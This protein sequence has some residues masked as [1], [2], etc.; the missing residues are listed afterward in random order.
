M[1][2]LGCPLDGYPNV[3][4][5]HGE[6]PRHADIA[7]VGMG[8]GWQEEQDGR[9]FVGPSGQLLNA[10]LADAGVDRA[11]VY[12]TNVAQ[13]RPRGVQTNAGGWIPKAK[14]EKLSMQCCRARCLAELA[15]VRPKIVVAVGTMTME[16]ISDGVKGITQVQGSLNRLAPEAEL[17]DTWVIPLFHPAHLLRG[18]DRFYSVVVEGLKKAKRLAEGGLRPTG[19]LRCIDPSSAT[20]A[21]DL[22]WLR[23]EIDS[24]IAA[25]DDIAV[26]VETTRAEPMDATLTV[27]GFCSLRRKTGIAV[28]VR[29]WNP[30]TASFEFNWNEQQWK[31]IDGCIRDL[32]AAK[33]RFWFW[34]YGFDVTV[35]ERHYKIGGTIG[36]GMVLHHLYQ[37]DLLHGLAFAAQTFLDI[38]PW[39]WLFRQAELAGAATHADLLRYNAQDVLYTALLISILS[40]LVAERGNA[41]LIEHQLYM[42]D[43]ARRA[44]LR[45]IPI[46]L[47]AWRKA[48]F[49]YEQRRYATLERIKE[50]IRSSD[51]AA[52]D[53]SKF[54]QDAR[55]WRQKRDVEYELLDVEQFNPAS[56]DHGR[57]LLYRFLKLAP[58][59]FTKGGAEGD[60]KQPS[61]SY[62]GVLNHLDNPLVKAYVDN[63]EVTAVMRALK[64]I[65]EHLHPVTG[66]LHPTWNSVGMAG[67]RWVSKINVQN[68]DS[69]LKS[70]SVQPEGRV[71]IAADAAQIEYRV[72]ALLAGITDLLKL[73][74]AP[75]FDEDSD[76]EG[77][78]K[79]DPR[80]D[81]HSML[82]AEVFG[83]WFLDHCEASKTHSPKCKC[84]HCVTK[85]G[86]RTL[87]KRVVYA[88]FYGAFPTKILSSL[89]EDRRLPSGFRMMLKIE[90]VE[91]I[92]Q[93]FSQRFREWP[94]WADREEVQVRRLGFQRFPPF[95]RHVWWAL[96]NLVE[97]TK[98]RN[99]PIQRAAGDAVNAMFRKMDEEV[100]ARGLDAYFV[101]HGHDSCVWDVA[102]ADAAAMTELV[103][104]N[105]DMRLEYEGRWVHVY[106]QAKHGRT[107]AEV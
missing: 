89:L 91:A 83:Q 10:M 102:A 16:M 51:G 6:G 15:E 5:V 39:K 95:D 2:C 46:D 103:N 23:S 1:P 99:T 20:V 80:Y 105:F 85:K 78:K 37:S 79:Y 55:M 58:S 19:E 21:A 40:R 22:A 69:I 76:E 14:V 59:R 107:M 25:G 9:P 13:C 52:A 36:D 86:L 60:D 31:I 81:A 45:G 32:L 49:T 104:R 35:L 82:A 70:I 53:L 27:F 12:I 100:R 98:I 72:A 54:V 68:W 44:H 73:F 63:A 64:S 88:L 7:I 96:K 50:A 17:P 97:V 41:H 77:W 43:M 8:P 18:E 26:D 101:L 30:T 74:N 47:E 56:A 33:L 65:K 62:K 24:I 84:T 92:W 61:H 87:V 4:R 90:R 57:W 71:W 75:P 11:K 67:T 94:R 66:R 3:N 42:S 48:Y 38:P 34:N 29:C 106:G 93:G 28:T